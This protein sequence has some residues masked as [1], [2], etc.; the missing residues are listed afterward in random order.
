MCGWLLNTDMMEEADAA[1]AA[2]A[3]WWSANALNPG[4]RALF[5]DKLS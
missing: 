4:Q 5:S 3:C 1:A 2:A